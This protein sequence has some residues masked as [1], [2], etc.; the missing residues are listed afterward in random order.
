MPKVASDPPE[1]NI[2]IKASRQSRRQGAYFTSALGLLV[3]RGGTFTDG[4][5]ATRAGGSHARK[6]CRKSAYGDAAVQAIR[7]LLGSPRAAHSSRAI[8]VVKMAR[9]WRPTLARTQ[10]RA[11]PAGDDAGFATRSEI[12]LPG[13]RK[14]SR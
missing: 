14:Y 11:D 5:A 2:V 4:S 6:L 7:D 9:R 13:R 3:D 10:G 12:G 1:N 8:G